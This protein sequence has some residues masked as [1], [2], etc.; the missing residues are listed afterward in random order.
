[1]SVPDRIE[2]E[3]LIRAPIARVFSA[4]S[5]SEEFGIWFG[6]AFDGPFVAGQRITGK[7]RPTKV[8]PE[9]AK[10]QTEFEGM[11]FDV[12]V[13]RIEP[14]RL[15]SFRW[16]PY[17]VDPG[18]DYSKEPFTLVEFELSDVD[19]GTK[20]KITES[21]FDKVPLERR[22]KAFTENEGGWEHQAKLV[23]K[24]VEAYAA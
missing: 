22:A 6:V 17:A 18:A 23:K 14:P 9:V 24:Y 10:L 20:L 7:M 11:S 12:T 1:M 19:G 13:E 3:I 8:D 5:K 21:G 15:F 2:K 16:H 4:I